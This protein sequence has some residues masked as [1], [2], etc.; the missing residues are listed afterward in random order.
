MF[1]GRNEG[2]RSCLPKAANR[3]VAHGL[4]K[5][6]EKLSIPLIL[7]EQGNCFVA[8][9]T[10]GR[11]LATGL[12]LEESQQVDHYRG[13]VVTLGKHNDGMTADKRAILVE[14]SEIEW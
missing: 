7:S 13:N 10:T 2:V 1:H 14:C 5:F 8:T 6:V 4:G 11:A 12:I 9:H 3:S